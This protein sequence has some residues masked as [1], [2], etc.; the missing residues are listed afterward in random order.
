MKPTPNWKMAAEITLEMARGCGRSF[1][2]RS[3][4]EVHRRLARAG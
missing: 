2:Q 1:D 3:L 4:A